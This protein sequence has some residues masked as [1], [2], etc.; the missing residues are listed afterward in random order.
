M[1]F[2][3]TKAKSDLDLALGQKTYGYGNAA[4]AGRVLGEHMQAAL[5][6]IE[7]LQSELKRTRQALVKE[8]AR[9]NYYRI[10]DLGMSESCGYEASRWPIDSEKEYEYRVDWQDKERTMQ[11]YRDEAKK[12]LVAEGWPMEDA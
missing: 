10:K 7:R 1:T 3:P 8:R 11:E 6:E 5:E 4:A 2:D 12:E 9:G